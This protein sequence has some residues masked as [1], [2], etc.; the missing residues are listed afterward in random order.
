MSSARPPPPRSWFEAAAV[1]LLLAGFL[2]LK[3][4]GLQAEAGDENIYFYMAWRVAEGRLPYRDFLFAHPPLHLVPAVLV[5]LAVGP[6]LLA[7]KA[8]AILS[9]AWMG[10]ATWRLGRRTGRRAEAVAAMAILL[11]SYD[12][13]RASSHFTGAVEAVA[14]LA[15]ALWLLTAGRPAIAGVLGACA[16]ATAVY[17]L[18]GVLA[19]G[20]W[21]WGVGGGRAARRYAVGFGV[22]FMLVHLAGLAVAGGA[23]LEQVYG[24]HLRKPAS[25]QPTWTVFLQL[26]FHDVVL[27]AGSVA[28]LP[29]LWAA[30]RPRV[31][32]G[33]GWRG[34]LADARSGVPVLCLG[35]AVAG[36][37]LLLSLGRLHH[38]YFLILFPPMAV[39]AAWGTGDAIRTLA[40]RLCASPRPR[41][42][43]RPAL[44]ALA[45]L[46]VA[47]AYQPRMERYLPY[48]A[49][50]VARG[51]EIRH[52]TWRSS[53]WLG[54]LDGVVRRLCWSDERVLGAR[55]TGVRCYL[56][57]ES[58]ALAIADEMAAWV[59][60][61]TADEDTLFGDSGTAPLVALLAH[62]RLAG[63][64][65]DT[66]ALVFRSG[67]VS[68]AATI[69]RVD[70][71]DLVYV[72]F[73][74]GKGLH[75]LPEFRAWADGGFDEERRFED[76]RQGTWVLLRR[77]PP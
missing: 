54:P 20:L 67:L 8:I 4:Y 21:A 12:L 52:Y 31:A 41:A 47:V 27:F 68:A 36:A 40:A 57:H 65:A 55:A 70:T 24:Y 73:G 58:V 48:Y 28:A 43:W 2:A 51:G 26:A 50:E 17:T 53:P 75:N 37:A 46:A 18:P 3:T 77:R 71:P 6:R 16:V 29:P 22:P 13:L 30:A 69:R 1:G 5:A 7:F 9:A 66:N 38:F 72:L 33:E 76:P 19:A 25:G 14:L 15:T 34:V 56:W 61:H 44:L 10:I 11:F 63:D 62:R 42:P 23:F 45:V 32:D 60:A 74:L 64:V 59:A 35:V 39:L 49:A